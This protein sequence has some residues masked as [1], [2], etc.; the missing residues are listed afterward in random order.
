MQE[1]TKNL[2]DYAAAST[3]VMAVAQWLPPIAALFTIVWTAIRIAYHPIWSDLY[4]WV[5]AWRS[6][7]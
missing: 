1:E 4:G 6:K 3:A 5:K 2:V 7:D